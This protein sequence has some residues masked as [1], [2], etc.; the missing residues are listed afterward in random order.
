[1]LQVDSTTVAQVTPYGLGTNTVLSSETSALTL[2]GQSNSLYMQLGGAT[3]VALGS[4]GVD[5]T[6]TAGAG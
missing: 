5:V 6:G 4:S 1:M 3:K 2:N